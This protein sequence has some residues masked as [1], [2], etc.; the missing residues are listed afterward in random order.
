MRIRRR[1]PI[2][3]GVLLVV[4]AIAIVVVLRKHAPPEPARLLPD[5]DGFFYVSLKWVRRANITGQ[6]PRVSHDPDYEKFI[7]ETGFEF[8]RDLNQAAFAIHY[9]KLMDD[10]TRYPPETRYSEVFIGKVHGERLK[11]YLQKLSSSVED[12]HSVDVYSIPLEGRTLR[13]AVLGVDMVAASNHPDPE[14]LHGIIERSRHLASPFG[15]PPMLRQYYKQ[16]PFA[17]LGW[18]IFRA[19]GG[20]DPVGFTPFSFLFHKPAV[21]V[22]SARYL[23]SVNF[24]AEAFTDSVEEA[25]RVTDQLNAFLGVMQ[26]AEISLPGQNAD[27][28]AK[29]FF[30]SLKVRQVN[31]RSILTAKI[32]SGFIRKA[33]TEP[34]KGTAPGTPQAP[35]PLPPEANNGG[36]VR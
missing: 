7:Q 29:K 1:L 17:A 24:R 19:D 26:S 15:G 10:G 33:L 23:G 16:V 18:A 36:K 27:A 5:A 34:S 20:P 11:A 4:A 14:V 28:D 30:A 35:G 9:P 32:P 6:L 21:V 25:R 13:V 2:L 22:A 12:Y 8:E 31:D 3:L